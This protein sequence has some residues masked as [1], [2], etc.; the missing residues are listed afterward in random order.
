V[1][2]SH[3]DEHYLY[4]DC[5]KTLNKVAELF[6]G[7][8]PRI[9]VLVDGPPGLTGPKARFPALP[10]LLNS[11]SKASIEIIMDDYARSEEKEIFESWKEILTKRGLAFSETILNLEKG[12]CI[13]EVENG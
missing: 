12:A 9:L 13:L 10:K 3:R 5:E 11:L 4:Y 1:D 2:Y 6:E 7:R 8:N